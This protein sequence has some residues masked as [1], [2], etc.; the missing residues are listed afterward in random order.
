MLITTP[1]GLALTNQHA[2]INLCAAKTKPLCYYALGL[3]LTNQHTVIFY[4]L[5]LAL[6]IVLR[7]SRELLQAR[8]FLSLV[9]CGL[10][11]LSPYLYLPLAGHQVTMRM[12]VC[13]CVCLSVCVYVCM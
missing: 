6:G 2:S 1:L 10:F 8:A 5:P 3:A 4:A 12:C 11:G 13:I 7:G 9:L